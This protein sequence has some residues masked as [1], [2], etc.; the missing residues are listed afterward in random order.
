[1]SDCFKVG[2]HVIYGI[3]LY[4]SGRGGSKV[5]I[6][7]KVKGKTLFVVDN[8]KNGKVYSQGETLRD[9]SLTKVSKK[10]FDAWMEEGL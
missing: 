1:M 5:G 6:I 8:Y 7:T 10:F 3:N 2:D 4:N 9:T